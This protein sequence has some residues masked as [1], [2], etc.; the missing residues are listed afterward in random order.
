MPVC[1]GCPETCGDSDWQN[2]SC[3]CQR[4]GRPTG[5]RDLN[6]KNEKPQAQS[7]EIL[8]GKN[9]NTQKM[10]VRGQDP[11]MNLGWPATT[12]SPH[13]PWSWKQR[14]GLCDIQAPVTT[15]ASG[16]ELYWRDKDK[17]AEKMS[18]LR[19][20]TPKPRIHWTLTRR[21]CLSWECSRAIG[22]ERKKQKTQIS[23]W[24]GESGLIFNSW[25]VLRLKWEP[26]V[27]GPKSLRQR[28]QT[29]GPDLGRG[30][31]T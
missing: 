25:K 15:G 12:R 23:A 16:T 1:R 17:G 10:G 28:I 21:S 27:G 9:M 4:D 20:T 14:Q 6:S 24:T 22:L 26:M 7:K 8:Q 30:W 3:F 19:V 18:Q 31:M 13:C 2:E 5:E 29:A 11:G